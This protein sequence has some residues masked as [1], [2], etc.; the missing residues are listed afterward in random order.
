MSRKAVC[1]SPDA[2]V[3]LKPQLLSNLLNAFDYFALNFIYVNW[4][5]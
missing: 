5:F 2:T 1:N 4:L 3:I